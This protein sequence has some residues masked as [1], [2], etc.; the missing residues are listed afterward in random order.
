MQNVFFVLHV[1]HTHTEFFILLPSILQPSCYYTFES[2]GSNPSNTLQS[3]VLHTTL[4][5]DRAYIKI[6]LS[7]ENWHTTLTPVNGAVTSSWQDRDRNFILILECELAVLFDNAIEFPITIC[8]W[9]LGEHFKKSKG[10]IFNWKKRQKKKKN[11]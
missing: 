7:T 5:K 9:Y 2:F 1:L 8:S 4:G 6:I 3:T 10:V 11:R